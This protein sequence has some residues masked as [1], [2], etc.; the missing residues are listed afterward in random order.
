MT[1]KQKA[2]VGSLYGMFSTHIDIPRIVHI[3]MTQDLKLDKLVT[4]KFKPADLNEV[5]E[6]MHKQQLRGRWVCAFD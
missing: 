3:A 1:F 6:K 5:A 4:T 2:I